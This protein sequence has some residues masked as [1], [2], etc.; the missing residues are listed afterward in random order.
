MLGSYR[1]LRLF[2][3]ERAG[4]L[5][6]YMEK[7]DDRRCFKPQLY[8][9]GLTYFIAKREVVRYCMVCLFCISNQIYR[10]F[11][12]TAERFFKSANTRHKARPLHAR[13]GFPYAGQRESKDRRFIYLHRFSA[14]RI[15]D[16]VYVFLCWMTITLVEDNSGWWKNE[17]ASARETSLKRFCHCL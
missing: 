2:L 11:L 8:E 16:W 5:P 12:T 3:R 1:L 7:T 13:H 10:T 6:I 15:I 17:S 14:P 4:G 9:Y